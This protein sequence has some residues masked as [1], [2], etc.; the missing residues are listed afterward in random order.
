M[1]DTSPESSSTERYDRCQG[2]RQT[3]DSSHRSTG[4]GNW[5]GSSAQSKLLLRLSSSISSC[6]SDAPSPPDLPLLLL[7]QTLVT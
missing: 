3:D 2:V 7:G 1:G 5:W 6:S 4:K